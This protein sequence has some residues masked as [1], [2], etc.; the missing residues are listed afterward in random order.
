MGNSHNTLKA[1]HLMDIHHL[2]MARQ[3]QGRSRMLSIAAKSGRK[4]YLRL[5]KGW[6]FADTSDMASDGSCCG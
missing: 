5:V 1:L 4:L 6:C 3:V 2:L